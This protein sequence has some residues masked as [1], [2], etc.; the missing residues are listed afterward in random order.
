MHE[1]VLIFVCWRLV[2][3][4]LFCDG[5]QYDSVTPTTINLALGSIVKEAVATEE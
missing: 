2:W 5:L 3:T 1:D 4:F